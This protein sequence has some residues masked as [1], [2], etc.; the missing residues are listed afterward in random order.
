M[1]VATASRQPAGNSSKNALRRSRRAAWRQHTGG[2][3][4]SVAGFVEGHTMV[5]LVLPWLRQGR[6]LSAQGHPHGRVPICGFSW[7]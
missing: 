3:M 1:R 4:E 2:W 7:F 6:H 5:V